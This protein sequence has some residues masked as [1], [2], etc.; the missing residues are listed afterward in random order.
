M[1]LSYDI[2]VV[3]MKRVEQALST[4]ERRFSQHNS[5]MN[6]EIGGAGGL[7]VAARRSGTAGAGRVPLG[8]QFGPNRAQLEKAA[9]AAQH[10]QIMG[11]I[12]AEERARVAAARAATRAEKERLA[13]MRKG[14]VE[15]SKAAQ[16]ADRQ[17]RRVAASGKRSFARGT[18][19]AL[20]GAAG[21]IAGIGKA[22]LALT[23]ISGGAAAGIAIS[24]EMRERAKA[25]QLANQ[26]G[27]PALKGQLLQDARG[28]RGF[29]GEEAL[30][31][32][33]AFVT[34][35]GDLEM[36]RKIIGDLGTLS[37]ATGANLDDL[38][39]TAGQAFNVIRDQVKD[40]KQQLIELNGI[41]TALAQQGN[42]GAVEIKDLAKDFGK[43]GA[44]TRGFE[45]GAPAL[46]RTMGAFAQL[47]VAR[48]GAEGSA[49]ASTAS[50]RLVG[51][52][53]TNKKKFK[54]LGVGIKSDIDPTKLRDP[55]SIMQD[56][57]QKTGGDVEKTSGLFGI[58][59]AKIFKGL[60]AVYSEAEKSKKGSGRGAV[61]AEFKRFAGATLDPKALKDRAASRL[62]DPD[63]QFKETMKGLNAAL[64]KEL[65]PVAIELGTKLKEAT[66][67]IGAFAKKVS[68][69]VMW[70]A[71]NPWK[72]IGIVVAG[73]L[74]KEI[75]SAAI[76]TKIKALLEGRGGA[77]GAGGM[78]PP[79]GGAGS[80]GAAAAGVGMGFLGSQVVAAGANELRDATGMK[81]SAAGFMHGYDAQGNFSLGQMVKDSFN[82]LAM[83]NKSAAFGSEVGMKLAGGMPELKRGT[84]AIAGASGGAVAAAPLTAADLANT[85]LNVKITNPGDIGTPSA[86]G[87]NPN[88]GPN[89]TP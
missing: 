19:G 9:G 30:G 48:G 4:I 44:A 33:E 6:R 58:E 11:Q 61:D 7:S 5:R 15:M 25:S 71:A 52:I 75:A 17:E 37:L 62:S 51:D 1:Q 81:R 43:L 23:G 22:G 59:S 36:A 42:M 64:A 87:G 21:T 88:R 89:P 53:V 26:A 27:D 45:G 3:G 66:P 20:G 60:S 83:F 24:T 65:L 56:V 73:A 80:L 54:A 35:T 28:V 77:G 40:P 29:T 41:M 46:L 34:K 55:L 32:M 47:A 12:R 85:T 10:R 86:G 82:P 38:G 79:G 13:A 31:G 18:M 70:L 63:I 84:G 14:F 78:K 16:A 49:D 74:V 76:A 69:V 57:L 50:A 67:A 8:V 68:E 39:E 72:G 2:S